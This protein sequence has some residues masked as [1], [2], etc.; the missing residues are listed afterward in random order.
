MPEVRSKI[1]GW[2]LTAAIVAVLIFLF[3]IRDILLPFILAAAISFVLYPV[4]EYI[5]RR[6]RVAHWIAATAVYLVVLAAFGLLAYWVGGLVIRDAV[7]VV[8]QFP[9]LLRKLLGDLSRAMSAMTGQSMDVSA[10]QKMVLTDLG[11]VFG[12]SAGL[13]LAGYGVAAIFGVFM[14][15]VLLIYFLISG[16]RVAEGVF[17]L[18]PPEYRGGLQRIARK[19]FPMLWRYFVGLVAVVSYTTSVAWLGFNFVFQV[20][21]APLLSI[22][23]GLLELVPMVGPAASLGLVGLTAIQQTSLL[24]MA[25][26]AAFAIGL[27][28]SIDELVGPL[29]LGRVAQ[30]HPVVIIFAFL[31]GAALFGVIGLLLAVPVAA[32]IKIVLTAYYAEPVVEGPPPGRGSPPIALRRV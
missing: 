4:V 5:A 25:G 3:F 1:G 27:R 7:E 9:Q 6:L 15:L 23:V 18:V 19:I 13:K 10:A 17:W 24:G 28:L 32:S 8:K 31:S 11:A 26:L 12:G 14:M 22:T 21:H 16:E 30:L 20:P 2:P 29:V